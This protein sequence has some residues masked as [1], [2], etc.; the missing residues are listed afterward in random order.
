MTTQALH[1]D[2]LQAGD[3]V[4]PWQIVEVLGRGGTSRVF[5]VR[6]NGRF[7]TLKM[8]LHPIAQTE[9]T[10][11]TSEEQQAQEEGV[12]RRLS[13]E[14]SALF[15]Y[16]SHPHLLRVYAVDFWPDPS[17][18]YPYLV[19]KFVDGDT[20]HAWRWRTHPDAC[21]L[22]DVFT[23]V[24]RTVGMLHAHGVYHRDIK[25]ENILIRREDSRAFLIDL[26]NARLPGAYTKT[27]GLPEGALHLVP[28]ELL[29]YT[30]SGA[31][32]RGE[33]FHGGVAADLY[34][35]GAL[36]YESLTD[37][38]PFD[39]KLPDE[40][41]VAAIASVTPAPPHEVNPRVPRALS[42]IALKLLEKRPEDRYAHAEALLHALEQTGPERPSP[43]WK[44][45]LLEARER[46]SA[47][48]S[49]PEE[50][51]RE[52]RA[53]PRRTRR[54]VSLLAGLLLSG[55]VLWWLRFTLPSP[56]PL[57]GSPSMPTSSLSQES[58]PSKPRVGLLAAWLC[59]SMSLGCP[60][61]Q[62]RPREREYCADDAIAGMKALELN[63]TPLELRAVL[64][65]RQPPDENNEFGVY[66]TGPLI[67]RTTTPQG[68]MPVGTLLYGYIWT[69]G[70]TNDRGEDAF[71]AQY[72]QA[73]L[74]DGRK[75]PVCFI[76]GEMSGRLF[77]SR[78]STPD[79]AVIRREEDILY[80]ER[81]P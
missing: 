36:L 81:W 25:A 33:A 62:V 42:D 69:S 14:V 66:Q 65:V 51:R 27:L 52:H 46:P 74:P 32:K 57:K 54:R 2:H 61:A 7:Y 23:D 45:P 16:A 19:T 76:V 26:G 6:R 80:V 53:T 17:G 68:I 35:L 71:I 55:L 10:P 73:L 70:I 78:G 5:K 15:T 63:K 39:P 24:V 56:S 40:V 64:D 9:D 22:V 31:W 34:A 38:H 12:H 50:A 67:G 79:T 18:G 21:T 72:T 58:T 20:W 60:G 1:P 47:P 29:A 59:A 30:R 37:H 48:P 49:P 8:A 4:G 44:V 41:L 28:P 13:R 11:E 75:Y 77:K 43:T 3:L